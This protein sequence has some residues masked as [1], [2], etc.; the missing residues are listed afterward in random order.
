MKEK[1]VLLVTGLHIFIQSITL[2]E[3]PDMIGIIQNGKFWFY[4]ASL[5]SAK[6]LDLKKNS[7]VVF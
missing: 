2:L 6:K 4:S 3:R 1:T 7:A 5:I